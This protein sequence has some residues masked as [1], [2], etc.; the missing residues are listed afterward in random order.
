VQRA[1]ERALQRQ[2]H[3][4]QALQGDGLTQHARLD[5]AASQLLSTA[6]TRLGWSGRATHRALRVARTIADMADSDVI[7]TP[8]VAEAIQYRQPLPS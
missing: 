4:N 8:H 2:G 5:A 6:A 1:R 3:A 7:L